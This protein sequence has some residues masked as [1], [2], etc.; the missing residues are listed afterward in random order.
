M[1]DEQMSDH[2]LLIRLDTKF[3]VFVQNHTSTWATFTDLVQKFMLG[4][5]K[6]A[7]KMDIL[8]ISKRIVDLEKKVGEHETSFKI[9]NGKNQ[10]A[11]QI[12]EWGLKSWG[13]LIATV[14]AI[15]GI[16]KLFR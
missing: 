3:E 16:L 6:K 2:D 1:S 4:I 5:D 13:A 7:D 9:N 15:A 12:G 11:F 14:A 10:F 8:E